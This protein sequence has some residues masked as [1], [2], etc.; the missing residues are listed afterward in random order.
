MGEDDYRNQLT[1]IL[2]PRR[3]PMKAKR[4][5]DRR[6][7]DKR[8]RDKARRRTDRAPSPGSSGSSTVPV[9]SVG[10]IVLSKLDGFLSRG[11]RVEVEE[12]GEW[13]SVCER[14]IRYRQIYGFFNHCPRRHGLLWALTRK[15][16]R[17]QVGLEPAHNTHA[18]ATH[19]NEQ[20][21]AFSLR[22]K[23]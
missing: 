3:G 9:D 14:C 17:K 4:V 21:L 2:G 12:R 16:G 22:Q 8:G 19:N 5:F 13:N 15:R 23:R 10:V 11:P 18:L 7:V 20:T 6:T 1:D